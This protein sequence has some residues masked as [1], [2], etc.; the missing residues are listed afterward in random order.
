MYVH[1]LANAAASLITVTAA[2]TSLYDLLDTA[3]STANDLPGDLNA[4][5]LIVED[6]DIRV[7]FDG[8][9]PTGANGL[10]L[11][12]TNIYSFRGVPL[13]KLKLIRTGGDAKV[14]VQVGRSNPGENNSYSKYA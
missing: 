1:K 8:N 13:T 6:D 2:A 3:A 4:V 9:K 7:L 12:V 11:K 14:S 10:L 5:D